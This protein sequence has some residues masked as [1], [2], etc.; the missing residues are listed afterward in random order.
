MVKAGLTDGVSKSGKP[1]VDIE[2]FGPKV[3]ALRGPAAAR[4]TVEKEGAKAPGGGGARAGR[5]QDRVGDGHPDHQA[6]YRGR[7]R[8]RPIGSKVHYEGKLTD[9]TVFDSSRKRGKPATFPLNG[10]I[11]C[12]TEGLGRMKVGETGRPDLPGGNRL[13]R[14]RAAADDSRWRDA[15]VRRRAARH[16]A[17]SLPAPGAGCAGAHGRLSAGLERPVRVAGDEQRDVVFA[18]GRVRRRPP[19]ASDRARQSVSPRRAPR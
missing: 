2:K 1:A 10:V 13:R 3:D 11:K 8:S 9:G 14:G 7:P 6:R 16:R 5:D 17:G 12:W 15:G 18:F 19:R 4:A